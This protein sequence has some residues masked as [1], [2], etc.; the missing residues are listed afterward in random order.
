MSIQILVLFYSHNG[1]VAKMA[2]LVARG[3]EEVSG[4][5]AVLR[6]VPKVSTVCETTEDEVPDSGAPYVTHDDLRNCQGLAL[7]SPTRFG[8]MA[9]PLKYFLDSTSTLW[10]SGALA[11]K[12]AAVFTS[13]SSLHGGQESTLL[14]MM[15]PLLHHGALIVGLPY[16]ETDLL[17]TRTGG[18]PYGPSHFAGANNDLEISAEEKNLCIAMGKRL[19]QTALKLGV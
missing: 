14:T 3:V 2:N 13:S 15:V 18:T 11:N 9:T 5:E 1:S 17:H 16:S 19:A 6:T 7:G 12:P 4:A 10:L 8:N